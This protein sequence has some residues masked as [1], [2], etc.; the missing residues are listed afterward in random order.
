MIAETEVTPPECSGDDIEGEE[1][2]Y[3][4]SEL[5]EDD[6]GPEDVDDYDEQY[7]DEYDEEYE[8]GTY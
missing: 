1:E 4:D 5:A 3:G 6:F 7:D 2:Y 8:Y